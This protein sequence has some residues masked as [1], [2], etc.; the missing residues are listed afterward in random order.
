MRAW[1]ARLCVLGGLL[2]FAVDAARAGA[3]L[4][5]EGK[6]QVI[7]TTG[8][9]RARG[10]YDSSGRLMSTPPYTKLEAR[11]F[12]EHGLTDWLTVLAE[13]D[14]MSFR[15]AAVPYDPL[16]LLIAQAKAGLPLHAPPSVGLTYEGLGLG[17]AGARLRLFQSDTYVFSVESKLRAASPEARRFLDMRDPVQADARVLMG[18]SFD[19]FGFA[20]FFDAQMGFRSGGQNGGEIRT[21]LTLGLR[22]LDRLLVMA[23]SYSAVSPR[24]SLTTALAQQKFQLSGV[25]DVTPSLSLQVGGV[26]APGGVNAPAERGAIAAIWWRY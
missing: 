7:L 4:F 20:G 13:G 1:V 24:A 25:Y 17:A 12:L 9:S 18:R 6:G 15:G 3:W 10:A 2:P 23:Q 14:A 19:L 16:D 5:P 8:F 22:P 11:A 26:A 21:D